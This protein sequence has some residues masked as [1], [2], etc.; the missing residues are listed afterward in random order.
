MRSKHDYVV[1]EEI[2]VV[3][4]VVVV[5]VVFCKQFHRNYETSSYVCYSCIAP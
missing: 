2:A 4:V 1:A 3:V 5:V